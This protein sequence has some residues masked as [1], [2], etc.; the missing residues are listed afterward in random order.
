MFLQYLF[1][2][3]PTGFGVVFAFDRNLSLILVPV[4]YF[5]GASGLA[6]CFHQ[7]NF[8]NQC[9]R[10]ILSLLVLLGVVGASFFILGPVLI[11]GLSR[12]SGFPMRMKG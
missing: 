6:F 2:L 9:L 3:I 1:C 12:I 4:G 11:D 8:C 5:I 7:Q 10:G